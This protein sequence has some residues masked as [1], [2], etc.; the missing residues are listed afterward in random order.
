MEENNEQI[1]ANKQNNKLA[2]VSFILSLVGLIVAGIPCGITAVITGAIGI[3]KFNPNTEKNKWMS[4]VGIVLGI[5]DIVATII[6][7]PTLYKAM[8]IM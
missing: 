8:G 1:P 6:F 4:I 2:L 7:L 3:S 5:I